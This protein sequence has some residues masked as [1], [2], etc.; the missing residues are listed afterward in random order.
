MFDDALMTPYKDGVER[1]L[2]VTFEVVELLGHNQRQGIPE[3][4]SLNSLLQTSPD[5]QVSKNKNFQ[6]IDL[7]YFEDTEVFETLPHRVDEDQDEP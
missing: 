2:P 1:V 6:M 7:L 4:T 3:P 5:A